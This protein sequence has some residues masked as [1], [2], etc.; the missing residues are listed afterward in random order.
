MRAVVQRTT[1]SS[2]AVDNEIVGK[3][4]KGFTV[5][6]GIKKGDT[7]KDAEYL[8]DKIINMRIFEDSEG[9]LNLS[10]NDVK[11]SLLL[12]SQFTLYGDMKKGR[13]PSFDEAARND[14]AKPLYEYAVDYARKQGI[15]VQTGIFGADMKVSILNDG[16]VT[17]LLDSEKKF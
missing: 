7:Q 5:L 10:L 15:T 13:R 2:V 3:I 4:G 17:I 14:E 12:I 1:G 16:P 6:W 8:I 9:K 11:G